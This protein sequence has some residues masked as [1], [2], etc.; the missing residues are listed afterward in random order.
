MVYPL[1]LFLKFCNLTH[2][3]NDIR[4]L[5]LDEIKERPVHKEVRTWRR[6]VANFSIGYSRSS[7][8]LFINFDISMMVQQLHRCGIGCQF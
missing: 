5:F 1:F 4:T 6:S 2:K 7:G 3:Q 8:S